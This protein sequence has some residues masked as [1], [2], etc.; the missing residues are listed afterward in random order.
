M[1]P[2]Q[3]RLRNRQRELYRGAEH[4]IG[5]RSTT[6]RARALNMMLDSSQLNVRESLQLR[7]LAPSV[8]HGFTTEHVGLFVFIPGYSRVGGPD[9]IPLEWP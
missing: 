7:I 1:T 5:L 2:E 6:T 8:R 3:R 9:V 4:L